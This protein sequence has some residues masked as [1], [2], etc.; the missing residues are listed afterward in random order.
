M[1]CLCDQN[2]HKPLDKELQ[3]LPS[4]RDEADTI[5]KPIA[6]SQVK[7]E[8]NLPDVT[9]SLLDHTVKTADVSLG[10]RLEGVRVVF[11]GAECCYRLEKEK[12]GNLVKAEHRDT[13]KK[14]WIQTSACKSGKRDQERK[15]RLELLQALDHPNVLKMLDVFQD[16]SH[17]YTVYEATEGGNAE[18]LSAQIGAVSERFGA[19]IM[20]QVFAGISHCHSKGLA[21]QPFSPHNIL[22]SVPFSE[23]CPAVKL[24]VP[25]QEKL[26]KDSPYVAPEFKDKTHISPV[27]DLWTC[28]V[29]LSTLISGQCIFKNMQAS[30]ISQKFRSAYNKWQEVSRPAKSLTLALIA[31]D[32][33][34]RPSPEKCLQH[35]WISDS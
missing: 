4:T 12:V 24:L 33:T 14:Y 3:P 22:F 19:A 6:R 23:D 17:I 10:K 5:R 2:R 21:L 34:K 15:Q 16:D 28:G 20:R 7:L 18:A 26:R 35:A 31:R 9:S 29:V 27:N 11:G 25:F 1:G 32:Y 13:R 30:F 8:S